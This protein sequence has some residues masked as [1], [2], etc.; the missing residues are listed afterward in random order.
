MNPHKTAAEQ[1]E[2]LLSKSKQ[3][4]WTTSQ[5]ATAIGCKRGTIPPRMTEL[6]RE[7]KVERAYPGIFRWLAKPVV[8]PS[9]VKPV[10]IQFAAVENPTHR[11]ILQL[12]A[13]TRNG[14]SRTALQQECSE[15]LAKTDFASL[16][17]QGLI[18]GGNGRYWLTEK[19]EDAADTK[20]AEVKP[21]EQFLKPLVVKPAVRLTPAQI[22]VLRSLVDGPRS[23]GTILELL[24][25]S[26][27][28]ERPPLFEEL[29]RQELIKM[30][31]AGTYE[32]TLKGIYAAGLQPV[33]S[34]KTEET[35]KKIEPKEEKPA[36]NP[37][38]ARK[39]AL[40]SEFVET[41]AEE[42]KVNLDPID[43]IAVYGALSRQLAKNLEAK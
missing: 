8:K 12:L 18:K 40:L 15:H 10:E 5:I 35:E 39:F 21:V 4:L 2:A 26:L 32:L 28:W 33:L 13:G 29:R 37:V 11:K 25:S 36:V 19:G 24:S 20:P 7:G 9:A 1:I 16:H 38:D 43:F 17:N 30:T 22:L 27:P 6:V 3:E 42:A 34:T 23:H 14:L 41:L 31:L